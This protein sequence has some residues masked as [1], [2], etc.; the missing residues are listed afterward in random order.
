MPGYAVLD[1]E[2]TGFSH[3]SDAIVEFSA[4]L[5][6]A[7]GVEEGV[8]TTL[9]NPGRLI[10]AE[11]TRVHGITDRMVS[12]APD[13]HR[14][15]PVILDRLVGR[16]VVG[17]NVSSFDLRFLATAFE[18]EGLVF[19]PVGILDTLSLARTALPGLKSHRLAELC[20]ISGIDNK[21]AHRAESDARATWHLLCALALA[22]IDDLT[23]LD[24]Y[25]LP[26][27][28]HSIPASL[29]A[30]RPQP[31]GPDPS[32][33]QTCVGE[34]VVFTGGWPEGYRTRSEAGEEVF[35]RGGRVS[36]SVSKKTTVVFAGD[37]AGSKLDRARELSKS[38]YPHSAFADFLVG[39]HAG[40]GDFDT[41]TIVLH[42]G[43][44]SQL[45]ST[46]TPLSENTA[47]PVVR[48]AEPV[49]STPNASGSTSPAGTQPFAWNTEPTSRTPA[50]SVQAPPRPTKQSI[51]SDTPPKPPTPP[52]AASRPAPAP[53]KPA[54]KQAASV[55]PAAEMHAGKP[56]VGHSKAR[57]KIVACVLSVLLG[58][59]AAQRFYLGY[60]KSAT[61][62]LAVF[63]VAA[64]TDTPALGAAV[65]LWSLSDGVRI[66]SGHLRSR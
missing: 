66:A 47:E 37:N 41:I 2:T 4:V 29:V 50:P 12:A 27:V 45:A 16:I 42:G 65:I 35:R 62:L 43:D 54:P 22:D 5:F 13:F 33:L 30:F 36:S 3:Q 1:L 60:R 39:G 19:K 34:V 46:K 11:T 58:F 24:K 20:R 44:V 14:V 55:K 26:V 8:Y 21:A 32:L 7:Q 9:V 61:A 63:L 51:Y 64:G 53:A 56:S 40:V 31:V 52:I 17:H 15:A 25:N 23:D 6:N 18:R 38:I 48:G 57:S 28:E 10:P 49:A 59:F